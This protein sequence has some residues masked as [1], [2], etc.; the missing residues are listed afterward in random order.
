VMRHGGGSI[1]D[2]IREFGGGNGRR[3]GCC[4]ESATIAADTGGQQMGTERAELHHVGGEANRGR[5]R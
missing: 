2:S 3:H 4:S 1:F 5:G